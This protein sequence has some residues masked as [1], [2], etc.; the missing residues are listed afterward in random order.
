VSR[1]RETV[2]PI[3]GGRDSFRV[4]GPWL[5]DQLWCTTCPGGSI[6]RERAVALVLAARCPRWRRRR[7]VECSPSPRGVSAMLARG[8]R[9]YTAINL[10]AD[11]AP[12]AV[13]GGVRNEDLQR[14]T[15]ADASI[16]VFVALDVLEHVPDPTAAV[17][18]ISRVLAADGIAVLTFPIR[19]GDGAVRP[20]ARVLDDGTVEHLAEPE[21]HGDPFSESGA[22]VFSDFGDDVH[23][24]LHEHSGRD[25][26]VVRFADPTHGVLGA[27]T[28]VC[29][30][31]PVSAPLPQPPASS[32]SP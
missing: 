8:A 31:G 9:R 14:L 26:E 2:C 19:G 28:E 15:L 22:L 29:V 17:R 20:R 21:W 30:L 24:W 12:G 11:A 7:V 5:R 25:V 16:D 13:V 1:P 3:C 6:P 4:D 32:T 23:G 18:E 27:L 10:F